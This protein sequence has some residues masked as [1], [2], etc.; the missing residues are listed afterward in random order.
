[1]ETAFST[2]PARWEAVCG[3]NSSA[4]GAFLYAVTTTGIYCR[5]GCASRLP[6][7]ENVRFFSDAA[8]A[9]R[10]GFRPCRRCRPDVAAPDAT[11]AAVLRACELLEQSEA[12]PDV[13]ALA[14]AAGLSPSHFHRV[15]VEVL[16]ATPAEYA[17]AVRRRRLHQGLAAAATVTDAIYDAGYGS[18]SRVYERS[19][20]LLGMTPARFRQGGAGEVVRWSLAETSLGTLLVAGTERGLCMVELGETAELEAR[21]RERFSRA[22]LHAGDE[23]FQEWVRAVV[24]L[25]EEPRRAVSLPLDI[26]GTAFQQ[27]V[28]KAL[29]QTRP[30]Q[31][32][33]YSELA[34]AVGEPRAARAVAQACAANPVAVVVPCHR[35]VPRGGGTGGYRWGPE[36]KRELL[37]REGQS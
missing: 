8:E 33:H 26:R 23:A 11:R 25:V 21:L 28:W 16:G 5:P 13:E 32:A 30:G 12:A 19:P 37:R 6:K 35:V 7:R 9:R 20:E 14:A 1:M 3:R 4:A 10:A 15:F 29:L 2:D 22:D 18:G 34:A 31:T 24:G 17:A 36:R 27:R